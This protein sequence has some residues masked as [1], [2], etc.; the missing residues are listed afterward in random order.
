MWVAKWCA[1][2]VYVSY[3]CCLFQSGGN[4]QSGCVIVNVHL[5]WNFDKVCFVTILKVLKIKRQITSSMSLTYLL[6][7]AI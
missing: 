5:I 2:N 4:E 6:R 7:L 1:F 3:K